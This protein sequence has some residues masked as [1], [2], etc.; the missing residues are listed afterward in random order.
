MQNKQISNLTCLVI[1]GP[2]GVGKSALAVKLAEA[3]N[4]EI[5]NGDVGQFYTPLSIGTAKPDWR[6]EPVPH[7]LFDIIDRPVNYTVTQY[8]AAVAG[9]IEELQSRG[10]T[11]II[12][13]GSLFY[14]ASLFWP[15][16]SVTPEK[17]E[18]Q[19]VYTH[20]QK[21]SL[22]WDALFAIDPERARAIHPNDHYR[23][24]RALQLY[25]A[26]GELPSQQKPAFEPVCENFFV[27]NVTRER[28][29][30]Y[31]R[32]NKRTLE[33]L[34]QRPSW[35]DEV[36]AL[37]P[38]WL[39]F[40]R[41]KGLIGYPEIVAYLQTRQTSDVFQALCLQIQQQTRHYAK[42][43]LT[44]WRMLQRKLQGESESHNYQTCASLNL[45]FLDVDLYI[46]HVRRALECGRQPFEVLTK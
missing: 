34:T 35:I 44:F 7:H 23:I 41:T 25:A 12:V 29:E 42:R 21:S 18:Q 32:I 10:K 28:E 36:A 43:Q 9:L 1:T 3:I 26:T 39:E 8:R 14:L 16:K 31:E 6:H 24:E 22:T 19:P 11:P 27:L 40:L 33:M 13:G 15:P 30:L 20:A 37:E 38:Q 5:I 17:G 2:T 4:G 45:T 46:R